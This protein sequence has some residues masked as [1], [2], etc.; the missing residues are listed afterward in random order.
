MIR[1]ALILDLPFSLFGMVYL[2]PVAY[3]EGVGTEHTHR[4]F[5][6]SMVMVS[7]I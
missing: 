3:L 4:C 7:G 5:I 1:A 6:G 2:F